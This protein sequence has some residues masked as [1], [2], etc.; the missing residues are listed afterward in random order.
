[1][2]YPRGRDGAGDLELAADALDELL[3]TTLVAPTVAR[4]VEGEQ[5]ALQLRYRDAVSEADR[6]ARGLGFSGLCPIEPQTRLMYTFDLLTFNR[7][8]AATNIVFANNVTDL[9]LTD[10]RKAFGA[11]RALP[12]SF[13]PATLAIPPALATTLRAL[14]EPS[15][16]AALGRWLDSR[17]VRALLERRDQLLASRG[18][19]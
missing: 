8:R 1:V 14:D 9:T 16:T 10:H 17:R 19:P 3:S 15:L 2:F 4:A 7:G 11:E 6:L 12:S 5:G 13:D 18:T